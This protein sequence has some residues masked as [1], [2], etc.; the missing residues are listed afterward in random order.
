M[1]RPIFMLVSDDEPRLEALRYDL[2]RRYQA[3]YQVSVASSAASALVTL[4]VL[5]GAGA[6]V[7]LIIADEHLTDVP[8][9]DL[10][11]R[12]HGLHPGAKRILLIDRGNW[13]GPHPAIAAMAMGRST[14]ACMSRGSRRNETC[15]RPC[16]TSSQ[17][18]TSP[19]NH[20][21]SPSASSGRPTPPALT[22][23]ART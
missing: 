14:T 3:D 5:A 19:V 20:P 2:N 16:P 11:A 4:A 7:A 8:A 17:P 23:S 6:E 12:V 13:T 9:A 15:T 22:G 21:T 18:G 10:L 1:Q